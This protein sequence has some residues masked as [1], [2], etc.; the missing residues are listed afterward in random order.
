LYGIKPQRWGQGFAAEIAAAV[1]RRG[2][3]I[4]GLERIYAGADPPNKAS[5]RV[6]EKIGMKFD[7]RVTINGVEA[8][9]YKATSRDV[10]M[11]ENGGTACQ[12][13]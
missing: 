10:L 11:P 13:Y 5:F 7:A 1:S 4:N 2:F 9:Y 3:E 6:M 8:L 12:G